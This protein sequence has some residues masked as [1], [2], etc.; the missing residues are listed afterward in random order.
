MEG[1]TLDL[2]CP[3]KEVLYAT[4]NEIEKKKKKKEERERDVAR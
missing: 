2:V 3:I 4:S 1:K